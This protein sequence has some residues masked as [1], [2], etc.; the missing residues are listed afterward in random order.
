MTI[1]AGIRIT[2]IVDHAVK[3]LRTLKAEAV[4]V[5]NA[6]AAGKKPAFADVSA[7]AGDAAGNVKSAQKAVD[8][9]KASASAPIGKPF[10]S[11]GAGASDASD[12]LGSLNETV[13]RVFAAVAG[14]ELGRNTLALIDIYGGLTARLRVTTG[15][16]LL[17]NQA[18]DAAR[19]LSAQYST[20][21]SDTA[22][23]IDRI[24][25]SISPLGGT[26]RNAT[27]ATEALLASL[28]ISGATAEE[29]SSAILQ[30]SQALGKGVL[31]GDEFN[32]INEAA[33]GLLR[34]LGA[35]LGKSTADL[36]K[37]GEQGT[38]TSDV[39]IKA[40]N[41]ALPQ[42]RNQAADIGPTIG[43]SFTAVNNAVT[44]F[45]GKG[46]QANG[47]ARIIAGGMRL[48]AD[49]IGLVV[50]GLGLL[51]GAAVIGGLGR[52]AAALPGLAAGIG[53]VALA[54]RGLIAAVTGPV[55]LIVALGSL[56]LAW[57]GVDVAQRAAADRTLERVQAERQRV[58]EIV[59]GLNAK[60]AADKASGVSTATAGRQGALERNLATLQKLDAEISS[61]QKKSD[62]ASDSVNI[63]A[64]GPLKAKLEENKG[65]RKLDEEYA[66]DREL[67]ETQ[68]AKKIAALRAEGRAADAD[69][70]A[71]DAKQSLA[72]LKKSHD[73][74][75][76]ALTKD[77]TTTRIAQYVE[78][79]DRI[80]TLVADG[81][82][83]ELK[84]LQSGYDQQLIST[85]AYFAQ[86]GQ[87]EDSA[88]RDAISKINDEIAARRAVL[89]KNASIRPDNVNDAASLAEA[90]KRELEAINKL[91]IDRV[92]AQR[93]L[94]DGARD[95]SVEES[96]ATEQLLRQRQEVDLQIKAANDWLT[97][98]DERL[99]LENQ[100]ADARKREFA[101]T[102]DTAQ[103]DRLIAAQL[104]VAELQRLQTQFSTLSETIKLKESDI[105][106]AVER[107]TVTTV[108]GEEKK[109]AA[110]AGSLSQLQAILTA[111]QAL[112]KT[113]AEKNSIES[114]RQ[115]L[116]GLKV[117]T[118]ELQRT[119]RE[120]AT[121]G[122]A[123]ALT[124][125]ETGAK[126]GKAALLD[127]VS[128]F[129]KA[130]LDVLNKRLAEQLVDQFTSAIGNGGGGG[131]IGVLGKVFGA[132][133]S[134]SGRGSSIISAGSGTDALVAHTGAMVGGTGGWMRSVPTAA[135]AFAP[136]YHS[137]GIAGLASNEVP[138][139]LQKGEEVL[140]ADDQRHVRNF[141]GGS[142]SVTNNV[143]ISGADDSSADLKAKA[144]SLVNLM[145]VTI[146][147]WA[148]TESRQGGILAKRS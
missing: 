52:L 78:A 39:I 13:K 62:A 139:V 30:F 61:L 75:V 140:T 117:T 64:D 103:T 76:K 88:K 94:R 37:M 33:P 95:R 102:G 129:A 92:K 22:K 120:S 72:R 5:S 91:E 24:F 146:K 21:L 114:L 40:A 112:A 34:A 74:A 108:D 148:A 36:K 119:M 121:S 115:Q 45:I 113:D 96:K 147:Q 111:M 11:L 18:M 101:E 42:L 97:V 8:D 32:S 144:D 20:S 67:I 46:A 10:A 53:G 58:Q 79:Y 109:F 124:D 1:D 28:K 89:A 85:K 116:D 141:S 118:T 107:G 142:I 136:R 81:T 73:D 14:I 43:G 84:A 15:S 86:R 41:V 99:R 47:T 65:K 3:A 123:G 7:G 23:L 127:M 29:S 38:L 71:V 143:Q 12:K 145:N 110:R 25:A 138:A 70:L 44:E 16:Q 93:D 90:N 57:V 131:F 125:I 69:N 50:N 132:F 4:G 48:L 2:A 55:G 19:S 105:D 98:G 68:S 106:A 128:G 17:F 137:G 35:A 77:E 122:L 135:F 31:N 54:T 26:L 87:L 83:R 104:R 56:A 133:S 82:D 60:N 59:D 130:M 80:A 27:V 9:L 126:S 6:V 100:F 51:A 63:R 134:S 66:R 49:N